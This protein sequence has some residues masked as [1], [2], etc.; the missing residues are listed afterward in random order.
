MTDQARE[1]RRIYKREWNRRNKE[2]VAEHQR[3]YWE[4]KAAKMAAATQE[5]SEEHIS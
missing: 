1:A 4:R 2:K 3:R 5:E